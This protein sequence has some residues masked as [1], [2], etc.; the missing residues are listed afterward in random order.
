[1]EILRV[2]GEKNGTEKVIFAN[3]DA[4]CKEKAKRTAA[5]HGYLALT[6][7]PAEAHTP[8]T[9]KSL[10]LLKLFRGM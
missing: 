4:R 1:M 6:T 8:A 2:Y 7:T 10:H 9:A 3:L 5:Q